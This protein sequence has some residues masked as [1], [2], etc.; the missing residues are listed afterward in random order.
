MKDELRRKALALTAALIASAAPAFGL[1]ASSATNAIVGEA[2]GCPYAVK[3]AVAC[4]LR[5]RGT[6]HGVYGRHAA[7]NAGEPARVWT[8]A[9]RAWAESATRD[10][11]HGATHFG[12]A[13]DV[14][15]GTFAG[16]RLVAVVG[17]GKSATYFFQ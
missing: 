9:R 7:H 4:A 8:D 12:N 6:L 2:A 13:A 16:L 15:R 1:S 10:V 14:A 11:T 17:T 3:V 5:N